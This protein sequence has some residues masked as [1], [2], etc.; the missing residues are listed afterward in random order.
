MQFECYICNDTDG[1]DG[2]GNDCCAL[3]PCGHVSHKLCMDKWIKT[4]P[5]T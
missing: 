5:P 1:E 3:V 2:E 4:K